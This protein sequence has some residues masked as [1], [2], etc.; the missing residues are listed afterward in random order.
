[1][2]A[3]DAENGRDV[4]K[5]ETRNDRFRRLAEVRVNNVI[6]KLRIL[7]QLGNRRVY[8]YSDEDVEKMFRA[9]ERELKKARSQFARGKKD[10]N[11]FSFDEEE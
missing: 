4:R 10:E 9:V 8:E 6:D 1:M 7:G 2:P 3:S 11:R 5:K